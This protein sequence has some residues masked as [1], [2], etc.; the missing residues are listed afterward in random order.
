MVVITRYLSCHDTV[1]E[2]LNET[3]AV[4][5]TRNRP[6]FTRPDLQHTWQTRAKF[7][8]FSLTEQACFS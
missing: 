6:P 3:P 4:A 5:H 2:A 7:S 1:I 8:K